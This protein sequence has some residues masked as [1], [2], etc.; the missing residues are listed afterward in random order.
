MGKA[1]PPTEQTAALAQEAPHKH[2]GGRPTDYK[3]EYCQMVVELGREGAGKAEMAAACGVV[4]Q[5]LDNWIKAHPEFLDAITRAREESLAWWEKQGRLGIFMGKT[6]NANA[7][8]LQ[9]FNRFPDDWKRNPEIETDGTLTVQIVK[10]AG[11]PKLA[12]TDP[13]GT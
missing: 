13:R 4:R 5:T 1:P 9:V 10:Y 12:D 2:A 7:Y 3:P 11:T 8:A 6:F